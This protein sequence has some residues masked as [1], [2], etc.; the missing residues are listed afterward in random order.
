MIYAQIRQNL[1][2]PLLAFK[3]KREAEAVQGV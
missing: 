2:C 1:A 3:R